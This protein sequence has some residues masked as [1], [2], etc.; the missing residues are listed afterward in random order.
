M[1]ES[2]SPARPATLIK[3]DSGTGVFLEFC[4]ISKKTFF[5]E[6]LWMTASVLELP[7]KFYEFLNKMCFYID[8]FFFLNIATAQKL[9]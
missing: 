1:S 2:L 4:K 9:V 8:F 5:T 6:H 3:R 7:K